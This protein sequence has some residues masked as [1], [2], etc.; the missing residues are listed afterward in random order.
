MSWHEAQFWRLSPTTS[1]TNGELFTILHQQE[2]WRGYTFAYFSFRNYLFK[3]I[4][5]TLRIDHCSLILDYG[6][7]LLNSIEFLVFGVF[8]G[9]NFS[10]N[11]GFSSTLVVKSYQTNIVVY[12][13]ENISKSIPEDRWRKVISQRV[14]QSSY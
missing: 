2:K 8:G 4:T 13:L 12:Q 3:Q 10:L 9:Q 11:H 7:I 5:Y 6:W 14:V 1:L